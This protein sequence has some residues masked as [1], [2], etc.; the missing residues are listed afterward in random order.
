VVVTLIAL[1]LFGAFRAHFT[2]VPVVRGALQ[3]ALVGAIAAGAAFG[4]ARLV[5]TLGAR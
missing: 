2:G 5:S 4:L 1:I 3:T